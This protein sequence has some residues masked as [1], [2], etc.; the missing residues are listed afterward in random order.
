MKYLEELVSSI[1]NSIQDPNGSYRVIAPMD[2]ARTSDV[3]SVCSAL[4]TCWNQSYLKVYASL[5]T[6]SVLA[7]LKSVE[8]SASISA[9]YLDGPYERGSHVFRRYVVIAAELLKAEVAMAHSI[10]PQSSEEAVEAILK[11]TGTV[12]EELTR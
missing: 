7:V 12:L 6:K 8:Q 9:P 3:R 5:R 10:L 4:Q 1:G 11:I 2:E